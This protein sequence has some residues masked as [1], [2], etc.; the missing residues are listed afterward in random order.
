MAE[1]VRLGWVSRVLVGH[2]DVREP[3]IAD[4]PGSPKVAEPGRIRGSYLR[5]AGH[6]GLILD[7][8][9]NQV[10][11]IGSGLSGV[12][13]KRPWG[14]GRK[15]SGFF[16]RVIQ[17]VTRRFPIRSGLPVGFLDQG[18]IQFSAADFR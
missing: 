9:G 2:V 6:E 3:E 5:Q 10:I 11:Q 4:A 13:C 16:R 15:K 7:N 14:A 12:S 1:P 17:Q 18:A 8:Q